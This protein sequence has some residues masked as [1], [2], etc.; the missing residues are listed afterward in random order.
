M[1]THIA[2]SYARPRISYKRRVRLSV[3]LS[4][5]SIESKLMT[6]GLCGLHRRVAQGLYF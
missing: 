2:F 1:L 5:A 6:V 3:C 4:H